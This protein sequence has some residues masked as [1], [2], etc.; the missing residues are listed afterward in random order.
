MKAKNLIAIILLLLVV[1]PVGVHAERISEKRVVGNISIVVDADEPLDSVFE[2]ARYTVQPHEWD[3]RTIVQA[4]WLEGAVDEILRG[5]EKSEAIVEW[6]GKPL[7]R[8]RYDYQGDYVVLYMNEGSFS[9]TSARHSE[10]TDTYYERLETT[11]ADD[12]DSSWSTETLDTSWYSAVE[13]TVLSEIATTDEMTQQVELLLTSLGLNVEIRLIAQK[14]T[15]EMIDEETYSTNTVDYVIMSGGLP[16]DNLAYVTALSQNDR[17]IPAQYISASFDK[18]GLCAFS[19]TI[20]DETSREKAASLLGYGEAI[21]AMATAYLK[22]M[23][24]DAIEIHSVSLCYVLTPIPGKML[25][26][27]Y[28]PAWRFGTEAQSWT[29]TNVHNGMIYYFSALTG[30]PIR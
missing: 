16:C 30:K 29:A 10:W 28:E 2:A 26:F 22:L 4:F 25:S 14:S 5:V 3:A 18:S 12:E 20:F 27:S 19:C 17:E 11:N 15:T 13:G 1:F 21:D 6:D 7:Y 8:E 23:A 24:S 9:F